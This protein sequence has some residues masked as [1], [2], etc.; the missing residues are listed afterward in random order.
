MS[1]PAILPPPS[2][3]PT[4]QAMAPFMVDDGGSLTTAFENAGV[5]TN[6][7][8]TAGKRELAAD[9]PWAGGPS[10][11]LRKLTHFRAPGMGDAMWSGACTYD[12]AGGTP[13]YSYYDDPDDQV[14]DDG[15]TVRINGGN[16]TMIGELKP[17]APSLTRHSR[18]AAHY[19][20][21]PAGS[22]FQGYWNPHWSGLLAGFVKTTPRPLHANFNPGAMGSKELHKATQYQPVPPMGSIVGYFGTEKA[23]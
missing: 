3:V 9:V 5:V 12:L 1:L 18:V 22:F 13:S 7:P 16:V 21:A 15:L 20:S 8:T 6:S 2:N 19:D 11:N 4:D 17:D 14:K 10:Q 23:L